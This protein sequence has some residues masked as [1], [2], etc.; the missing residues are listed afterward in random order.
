MPPGESELRP[1]VSVDRE[2]SGLKAGGRVAIVA[3][4]GVGRRGKLSTVAIGMA[5][6]AGE[7][8]GNVH[9][10]A[11]LR[12]MTFGAAER[13]VFSFQGEGALTVRFAVKAGG[14]EAGHFV[15]GAAVGPGGAGGELSFVRIFM[16]VPATLMGDGAVEIG[17]LVAFGASHRRVLSQER[18]F[19]GVVME[20]RAWLVLLETVG[21]VAGIAGTPELD[22]LKSPVVGIGVTALA[23]AEI[24]SF[25][26]GILLT[27]LG[28]MAFLAGLRLVQS[29]EREVGGGM[30]EAG[31]RL[32]AILGVTAEAI[33]AQLA[34]M[35]ILV[36]GKAVAAK[37]EE[38]P[39]R[40]FELDLG[41]DGSGNS[42]CD[43]TFLARLPRMLAG[44]SKTRLGEVIEF[45]AIET[46]QRCGLP[47][48]FLVAAPAIGLAFR[49]AEIAS[50][51]PRPGVH[52]APDFG[53]TLETL[54]T[55]R[56]G[57][58]F[59]TGRAFGNSLQLL[60][61]ARQRA[62]RDLRQRNRATA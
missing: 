34:L 6:G 52:P 58:K 60:V 41:A 7:F 3:F 46:N 48:V 32:E 36:T 26:L 28:S 42:R 35:L 8:A 25:E 17:A 57:A 59:V 49:A 47:L 22:F 29:G 37:A 1:G 20:V 19:G 5:G 11:A 9:R 38:R 31:G 4:V 54:E 14:F 55:A 13:G 10:V 24:Q 18:E 33:G 45:L 39:V 2:R 27:G 44:Q 51:K 50:M 56:G 40:I 53:V 62:G 15:T 61:S 43:V 12:L 23:A 16:A 30:I 21:V